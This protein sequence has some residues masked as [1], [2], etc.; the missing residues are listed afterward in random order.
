LLTA[1]AAS[2]KPTAISGTWPQQDGSA[3]Q[4][5]AVGEPE[6]G[7]AVGGVL[8]RPGAHSGNPLAG[9]GMIAVRV[10]IRQAPT[11]PEDVM[12]QPEES[13]TK[14]ATTDAVLM[15]PHNA[16]DAGTAQGGPPPQ[17]GEVRVEIDGEMIPLDADGQPRDHSS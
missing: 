14:T 5:C 15:H 13:R 2:P 16:A 9:R 6:D 3:A 10:G 12:S 4:V 1:V 8:D 7:S 17:E 11:N